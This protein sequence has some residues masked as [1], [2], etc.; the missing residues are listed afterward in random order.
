MSDY[1]MLIDGKSVKGS[2]TTGVVNPATGKVFAQVP[3]CT[4]AELDQA[5]AAAQRAFPA[6]SRDIAA[7]RKVLGEI[8]AALQNPPEG[9]ARALTMEQGKPL[10]KAGEEI[11]GAAIWCQYTAGLEFPNEVLQNTSSSRI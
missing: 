3:D 1:N 8:G 11:M 7:R 5:M 10:N 9:L 2:R 4:K 6:W